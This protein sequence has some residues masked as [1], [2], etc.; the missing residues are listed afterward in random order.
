VLEQGTQRDNAGEGVGGGRKMTVG[1]LR[2]S[3]RAGG[4]KRKRLRRATRR[5]AETC[6][7]RRE[8]GSGGGG[9]GQVEAETW[10][11]TRR[12]RDILVHELV[13]GRTHDGEESNKVL[14]LKESG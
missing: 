6:E 7:C 12:R 5:R 11:T 8:T 3:A 2:R 9:L 14:T 13:E 4:R 10:T 1:L